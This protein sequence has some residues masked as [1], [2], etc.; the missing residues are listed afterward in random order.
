MPKIR[1]TADPKLPRDLKHLAF[2]KDQIVELAQD[3]CDRWIRR[4]V[5]DM[6]PAD[7]K[8]GKAAAAP[9][10]PPP[11]PAG[12]T[13]TFDPEKATEAE[14]REFLKKHNVNSGGNVGIAKLREAAAEIV[15]RS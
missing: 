6:V 1:F 11:P 3:Q 7:T 5:A 14:L 12:G 2:K 13:D 4:G 8:P 9:P 15:K 10:P